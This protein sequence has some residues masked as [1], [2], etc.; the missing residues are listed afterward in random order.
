MTP[1]TMRTNITTTIDAMIATL[2]EGEEASGAAA[3]DDRF[4]TVGEGWGCCVCDA[5]VG[6]GVGFEEI[7]VVVD[8]EWV[9]V[10]D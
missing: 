2:L 4:D 3:V 9:V 7:V 5:G 6:K 8:V 1:I 10:A